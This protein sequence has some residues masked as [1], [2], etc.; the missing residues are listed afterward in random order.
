MNFEEKLKEIQ[1]QKSKFE[2]RK[3][4]IRSILE[5]D[6][7]ADL[8]AL[9]KEL[10]D[11]DEQ[12]ADL[13][14]R[15]SSIH[16]RQEIMKGI[17][18]GNP[19]GAEPFQK[20]EERGKMNKRNKYDTPE[21]REAFMDYV[22]RGKAIPA[23]YRE[24][25]VTATTDIGAIVPPATLNKIIE[26]MSAYGMILPLVT[27]TSY[28]TGVNIPTSSVKP[29]ATW[30][31]EGATS[32]KQ[33]KAIGY[34]VFGH[35]K[36]RCA[37][38]VTI[39]SENMAYSAFEAALVSNITEAMATA[40]EQAIIRGTG[41][42]QPTG[43]IHDLSKGTTIAANK[44]TYKLLT[45]A[46]GALPLAY[47]NGAVWVM[48][49][50]TFEEFVGMTD[51]AGQPIA[52][53][54]YG[55]GGNPERVLLGRKVV[56]TEYMPSFSDKLKTTDVYAFL[57]RMQDYVL[58]TN[59]AIGIKTYEDN[60]TDDIVRKSITVCDGKPVDTNSLVMLTGT[61]TA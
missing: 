24:A 46:E 54:N 47:E 28:A 25:G 32:D 34:I 44:I 39:E 6:E 16:K 53:V 37:V 45:Q 35:N 51:T 13:E 60:E 41:S 48:N 29:V 7:G 2:A 18:N 21:Y 27:K 31:A 19:E 52:R 8:D 5:K 3:A 56:L 43:I 36:L 50:Q 38:A 11:M 14:K 23:E 15:E 10:K 57:F 33:K 49:K 22:C 61:A 55:I 42:G 59:F 1:K 9:Q 20:P 30:V 17:E 12:M 4:E 26:K 58:N 40:I